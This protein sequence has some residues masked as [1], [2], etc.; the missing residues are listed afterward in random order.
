MG[1]TTR[2]Y[3]W[4]VAGFTVPILTVVVKKKRTQNQATFK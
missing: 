4:M 1:S 3:F 2:W